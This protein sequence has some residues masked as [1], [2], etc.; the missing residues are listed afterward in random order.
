MLIAEKQR[1]PHYGFKTPHKVKHHTDHLQALSRLIPVWPPVEEILAA[2]RKADVIKV[3]DRITNEVTH[4]VRPKTTL[5]TLP[6]KKLPRDVVLKREG[7][8]IASHILL[9]QQL[10]GTTLKVLNSELSQ[11]KGRFRWFAQTWI[12]ELRQFGE[13]RVFFID[14]KIVEVVTTQPLDKGHNDSLV[15]GV[16]HGSWS[17]EEL[18]SVGSTSLLLIVSLIIQPQKALQ[19]Q[20]RI[21]E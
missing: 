1:H 11:V 14:S 15:I 8:D 18:T 10:Q 16:L 21:V 19:K 20:P 7:S 13:W 17:L 5:L 4:T 6:L 9:P 12:P 2:S 3:Y